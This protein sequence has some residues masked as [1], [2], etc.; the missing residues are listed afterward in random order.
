MHTCLIKT[1]SDFEAQRE[2]HKVKILCEVNETG[3]ALGHG[4]GIKVLGEVTQEDQSHPV[5]LQTFSSLAAVERRYT[6]MCA[7]AHKQTILGR[8][9]QQLG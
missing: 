3:T 9:H 8:V 1:F 5:K 2:K 6:M 4:F 7:I